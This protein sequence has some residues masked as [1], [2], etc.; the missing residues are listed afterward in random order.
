MQVVIED[1]NVMNDKASSD[2]D[3]SD[4]VDSNRTGKK[5]LN[6]GQDRTS[7][8]HPYHSLEENW[9]CNEHAYDVAMISQLK[10]YE[11][12]VDLGNTYES[13]E[14]NMTAHVQEFV[15]TA[16]TTTRVLSPFVKAPCE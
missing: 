7:Y 13:T 14:G 4:S 2:N 15:N 6:A 11:N 3:E 9:R 10:S 8:E 1:R 16:D 12:I 5:S